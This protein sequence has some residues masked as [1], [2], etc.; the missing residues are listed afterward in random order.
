MWIDRRNV[1]RLRVDRTRHFRQKCDKLSPLEPVANQ[2]VR[3]QDDPHP[4]QRGSE[5][6]LR[7]IDVIRATTG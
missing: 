1:Q 2:P 4:A 6:R 7:I 5:Q 3:K